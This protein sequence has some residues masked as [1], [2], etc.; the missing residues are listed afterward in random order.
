[1]T[2]EPIDI[3][4]LI[5]HPGASRRATVR[6]EF[7]GLGTELAVVA[8]PVAGDLLLESVVEG[9]LVS[10]VLTGS[11]R[12]RCAR[13]LVDL[14]DAFAIEVQELFAHDPDPDDETY[15]LSPEGT[16]DPEPMLRD[17]V[18]VELPF[19]PLCRPG[20]L[21]LCSVCGANRN[22]GSCPGHET[23]D[24]RWAALGSLVLEPT[25]EG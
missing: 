12:L 23:V 17:A 21:G 18:G 16:I 6:G 22:E 3:R 8:G 11:L 15:P 2:V 9:V 25:S 19:A 5:D 24:P 20:C 4:D 13:C 1:M 10:G 14:D 7:D